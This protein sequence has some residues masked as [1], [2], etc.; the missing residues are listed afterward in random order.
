[1]SLSIKKINIKDKDYDMV[2]KWR[3]GNA[4]VRTMMY[5]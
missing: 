1:M 3:S 4:E 5:L 2:W